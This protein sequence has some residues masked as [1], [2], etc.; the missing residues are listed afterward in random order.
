VGAEVLRT[1]RAVRL[2]WTRENGSPLH[3]V[4]CRS[5]GGRAQ[6]GSVEVIAADPLPFDQKTRTSSS[7]S[8]NDVD[9]G[10]EHALQRGAEANRLKDEFIAAVSHEL[11]R[12]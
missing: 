4:G 7:S 2:A 11:A 3:A 8:P 1:N 10:R 9:R 12:R 6:H 5:S